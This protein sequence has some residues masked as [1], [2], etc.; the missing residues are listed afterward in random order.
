MKIYDA[1][2]QY[3]IVSYAKDIGLD[4]N[5]RV[6][7][8]NNFVSSLEEKE[9]TPLLVYAVVAPAYALRYRMIVDASSPVAL[10]QF[11]SKAWA[12][13][14]RFAMP[15][16]LEV[17]PKILAADRGFIA[18]V[19]SMGV[20][21]EPVTSINGSTAYERSCQDLSFAIGFGQALEYRDSLKPLEMEIAQNGINYYDSFTA[22]VSSNRY[23]MEQLTF[24]AWD[25][26]EKRYFGGTSIDHDWD[27]NCLVGSN[28][29]RRHP[30]PELKVSSDIEAEDYPIHVCGLKEAVSMWPG[31]KRQFLKD[32][33]VNVHDFDFW[34]EGEAHLRRSD[35]TNVILR[36]NIE[37][38][39]Q[40]Y[41]WSMCGGNL[42]IANTKANVKKLFN[43]LSHGGDICLAF[44][45]LPPMDGTALSM[46]VLMV[47]PHGGGLTIILF[48]R[49]GKA[50]TALDD[51]CLNGLKN[52]VEATSA[53]WQ[54]ISHII[55][56]K[57]NFEKPQFIGNSFKELHFDWVESHIDFGL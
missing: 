48:K 17:K 44:E 49:D 51:K 45:V 52:P 8:F 2:M 42:F 1:E 23:S 55:E 33:D 9:C 56:N 31:G 16:R 41:E 20:Q 11:L 38:L 26:R 18:W 37:Y 39:D 50:E 13:E 7:G 36:M 28:K 3:L 14:S 27:P 40:F 35:F 4:E 53:V 54:S 5:K 30:N 19:R 57:E 15:L 47:M 34:V 29:V 22:R 43:E 10:S 32:A 24:E 21:C 46:R 25:N 6:V 12:M